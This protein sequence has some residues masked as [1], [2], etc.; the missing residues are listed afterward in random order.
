MIGAFLVVVMLTFGTVLVTTTTQATS[1]SEA[2]EVKAAQV[3]A[4]IAITSTSTGDVVGGTEITVVVDNSGATSYGDISQLDVL[5]KYTN[6]TGDQEVGRL[7]YVCK[8]LCGNPGN[9]GN[10]EWTVSTISPDSYNPRMWDPDET[11]TL[12]LKVAPKVKSGTSGT[13]VVVLPE[14]VSDSAYFNN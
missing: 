3:G 11:A 1:L 13:V 7:V 9:P 4:V 2:S 12:S 10:D 8:Q 5:A 6:S 14:G